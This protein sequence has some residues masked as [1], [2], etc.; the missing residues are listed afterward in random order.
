MSEDIVFIKDKN[1]YDKYSKLRPVYQRLNSKVKFICT[2]CHNES[3]KCFKSLKYPFLCNLCNSES[4]RELK[5]DTCDFDYIH[6]EDEYNY[7]K[8]LKPARRFYNK[9]VKF[10]CSCCNK[11]TAQKFGRLKL[12]LLCGI[13]RAQITR[14]FKKDECDFNYVH[15]KEEYDY[16]KSL[17]P[18]TK[19]IYRKV[20]FICSVCHKE[21]E[22]NFG[23]LKYPF[24]CCRCNT[25]ISCNSEKTLKKRNTT[26]FKKFGVDNVQKSKEIRAKRNKTEQLHLV[27]KYNKI[28]EETILDYDY[29]HYTCYCPICQNNFKIDKDLFY[30]RVITHK[31]K[32]CPICHPISSC[33]SGKETQL[34]NYI[35]T[36]H[37]NILYNDKEILGG[38]EIDIYLPD[39]KLGFEFDGTY[40]H[41]DPRFYKADQLIEHK[42]VTAKEIWERDKEKDNLCQ[43]NGIKLIRILEYDWVHRNDSEKERIKLEIENQKKLLSQNN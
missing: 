32:V 4:T 18:P 37:A 5:R 6:N 8:A 1:D 36:L 21:C 24:I 34:K 41:A 12:P 28:I 15:N 25:K 26:I 39:L 17:K 23:K 42:R 30:T 19:F 7:Y 43:L 38:K 35:A 11:E 29:K 27:E 2:C 20:K 10:I 40:W 33:G 14:N 13:C 22:K 3:I 9:K 31:T 16:Y